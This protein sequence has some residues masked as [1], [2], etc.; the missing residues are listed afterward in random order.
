MRSCSIVI[1]LYL[2][3]QD[4]FASI[5]NKFALILNKLALICNNQ[6]NKKLNRR[7]NLAKL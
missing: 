4:K 2:V 7:I 1:T 5:L 6:I 3:K